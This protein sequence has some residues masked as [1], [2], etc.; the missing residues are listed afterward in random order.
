MGA[1]AEDIDAIR[2]AC[3]AAVLDQLALHQMTALSVA[4]VAEA[5][6]VDAAIAA[7]L[8]PDCASMIEQGLRDRD[9]AVLLRL[10]DDFDV[11][12]EASVHDKVLEGLIARFED[13]APIKPSIRH[14]N[15]A[16]TRDPMLAAMLINRLNEAS[17]GLLS[18]AGVETEGLAG[19]LRVK[20][21]SGVAL[22]CHRDWMN[23]DSPDLSATIRS[24]DKRLKQA[25]SIGQSLRLVDA[26]PHHD[27]EEHNDAS[28]F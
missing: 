2:R 14:L 24:L 12:A 16:A 26:A 10:A 4:M 3:G 9:Q 25:E 23:D 7:R 17:R 20:G 19:M 1:T 22:A 18:L 27:D 21:L 13:Y 8:F 5:A 6:E 11:D 15:Q 28:Q